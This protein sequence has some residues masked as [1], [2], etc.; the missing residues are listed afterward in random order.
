MKK[1]IITATLATAASGAMAQVSNF[2]GFSGALNLNAVAANSKTV[3]D[4]TS[5]DGIGQQSWIGSVQAAYGFV[6]SPSTVIAVGG[7]YALGKSKAG[8]L[9]DADGLST[10]RVMNQLS[11]YLEPGYLLSQSTLAYAK[12]SFNKA[13]AV[14]TSTGEADETASLKGS[15]FGFGVRTL[16]NQKTFLQVEVGQVVYK[17]V[18]LVEGGSVKPKAIIGTV[19]LGMKF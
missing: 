13:K 10:V 15:G 3:D 18:N 11:L 9:S 5:L 4:G 16:L 17:S 6:T 12:M 1:L 14:S 7:T 8:E 2:A 19:G